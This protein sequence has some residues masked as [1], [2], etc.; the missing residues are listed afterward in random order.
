MIKHTNLY[1]LQRIADKQ[2][3][4]PKEIIGDAIHEICELRDAMRK[5][6]SV[7]FDALSEPMPLDTLRA[8]LVDRPK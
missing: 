4:R 2:G 7:A 3:P 1:R 8:T 6:N 5:V